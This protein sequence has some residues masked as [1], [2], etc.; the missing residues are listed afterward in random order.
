MQW[1]GMHIVQCAHCTLSD[2]RLCTWRQSLFSRSLTPNLSPLR[3][4]KLYSKLLITKTIIEQ[5]QC[6][7]DID[8]RLVLMWRTLLFDWHL[9]LFFPNFPIWLLFFKCE[10]EFSFFRVWYVFGFVN[11]LLF[12]FNF[13][14]SGMKMLFCTTSQTCKYDAAIST[15][16]IFQTE[17]SQ[18]SESNFNSRNVTILAIGCCELQKQTHYFLSITRG[19]HS[20]LL[21]CQ[22]VDYAQLNIMCK[23]SLCLA[24]NKSSNNNQ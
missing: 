3:P 14:S 21:M 7:V 19:Y 9:S 22:H 11:V 8:S 2:W 23:V 10:R 13:F 6:K 1:V 17:C 15:A 18:H 4:G 24:Q 16:W 5:I 12:H 20:I